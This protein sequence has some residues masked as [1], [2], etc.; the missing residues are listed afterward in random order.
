[1]DFD[2]DCLMV[3][4]CVDMDLDQT[5]IALWTMCFVILIFFVW[6]LWA[7][8]HFYVVFLPVFLEAFSNSFTEFK[9]YFCAGPATGGPVFYC[10]RLEWGGGVTNIT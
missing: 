2:T 1:M 5:R 7:E 10:W 4:D 9:V 8:I 3:H 6:V